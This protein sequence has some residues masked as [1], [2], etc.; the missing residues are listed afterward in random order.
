MSRSRTPILDAQGWESCA[1]PRKMVHSSRKRVSD[2]KLR[3]FVTAF[4]RT[5]WG[6][7]KDDPCKQAVDVAERFADGEASPEDLEQAKQNIWGIPR[8]EFLNRSSKEW[9]ASCI[10]LSSV[11][12]FAR[13]AALAAACYSEGHPEASIALSSVLRFARRAALAAACYS[14]GP[15]ATRAQL[16]ILRCLFG[17]PFRPVTF[18]P[19]WRTP[20]V[21]GLAEAAYQERS[22]PHGTLDPDRLA[23][24]ADA[25]EEAGCDSDQILGHLRGPGPHYR[26]CWALDL[27][28][29]RE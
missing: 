16:E 18:E 1:S 23:I 10:A 27:L 9:W 7:L 5:G 20:T 6:L 26:G 3:L 25:L 21:R 15:P 8:H 17:N 28:L 4:A 11:W 13:R 12:K 24:L 2:R 29:G 19:G 14:E 22:L